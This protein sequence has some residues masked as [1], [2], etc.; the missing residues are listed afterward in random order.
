MWGRTQCSK[1]GDY[2]ARCISWN[3]RADRHDG[4]SSPWGDIIHFAQTNR[5]VRGGG[6]NSVIVKKVRENH[7]T[8]STWALEYYVQYFKFMMGNK[9]NSRLNK[10]INSSD[11]F[12]PAA[13]KLEGVNPHIVD[14]TSIIII[15]ITTPW[16]IVHHH[17]HCITV[18]GPSSSSLH[19][20]P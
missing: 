15:I 4:C 12:N 7:D 8:I 17:N 2:L 5:R 19:H 18:H 16:S 9:I 10:G 11:R 3:W 1:S 14:C 20:G 13:I 6:D